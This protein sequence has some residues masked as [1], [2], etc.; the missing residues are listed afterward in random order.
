MPVVIWEQT[1]EL[2][3]YQLGY[4][5][6]P[7]MGQGGLVILLC[8]MCFFF[9]FNKKKNKKEKYIFFFEMGSCYAAQVECNGYSQV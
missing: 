3:W 5:S 4:L 9:F 2:C 1:N 6:G 7:S 8:S